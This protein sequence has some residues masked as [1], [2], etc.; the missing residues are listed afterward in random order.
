[1]TWQSVRSRRN[2]WRAKVVV[3]VSWCFAWIRILGTV[4][5]VQLRRLRTHKYDCH[6]DDQGRLTPLKCLKDGCRTVAQSRSYLKRH[7]ADKHG[8]STSIARMADQAHPISGPLVTLSLLG[9]DPAQGYSAN[10]DATMCPECEETFGTMVDLDMHLDHQNDGDDD[11]PLSMSLDDQLSDQESDLS[12]AEASSVQK[13]S[14]E[15]MEET[16]VLNV[17][18]DQLLEILDRISG[19]SFIN[20]FVLHFLEPLIV[21][22]SA[23]D[24]VYLPKDLQDALGASV[25]AQS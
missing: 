12:D 23:S 2:F 21:E 13:T 7:F 18:L 19:S 22:N 1:M 15:D 20:E 24:P 8:Y 10:R 3:A 5:M 11:K 4:S 25:D 16:H 17:K 6:D 14:I 9:E